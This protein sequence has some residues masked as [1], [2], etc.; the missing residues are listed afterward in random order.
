MSTQFERELRTLLNKY[1]KENG[2]N[3]PDFVL[4][5]YLC[6]CL[7]AFDDGV[8]A[9]SAWYGTQE[10]EDKVLRCD[11]DPNFSCVKPIEDDDHGIF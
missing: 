2:S 6:Q 1:S 9:R 5:K 8:A 4:A 10:H 3:T 7:S 11:R